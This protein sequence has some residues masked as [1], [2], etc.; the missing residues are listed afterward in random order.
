[1]RKMICFSIGAIG[2]LFSLTTGMSRT[3]AD[4]PD[5][6]ARVVA[7]KAPPATG[8]DGISTET[9]PEISLL[10]AKP[11]GLISIQ[12]LGRGD[13]RMTVSVTNRTKRK[14]RVVL[15]PGV[16]AQALPA[17]FGCLGGLGGG[18]R[19]MGG[20]MGGMGVRGAGMG[21]NT[22]TTPSIM[23]M[24]VLS[25]NLFYLCG[26]PDSWDKRS[27]IFGMMGK[28]D[29]GGRV[30]GEVRAEVGGMGGAMRSVPSTELPSALLSPGQTRNLPTRLV[31]LTPPDPRWP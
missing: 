20:A 28:M 18:T 9:I 26:D 22:G 5:R 24:M 10:E 27:L 4:E 13:G 21:L 12:A 7:D 16:I 23:G 3:S 6:P 14:L 31:L 15:P 29:T 19:S 25:R 1:M 30:G 2:A 17:E 11:Q 8:F